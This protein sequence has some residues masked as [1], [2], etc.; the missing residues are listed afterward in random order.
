M[1]QEA[2]TRE[3]AYHQ[4]LKRQMRQQDKRRHLDPDYVPGQDTVY[5]VYGWCPTRTDW[6]LMG[7]VRGKLRVKRLPRVAKKVKARRLGIELLKCVEIETA[8]RYGPPRRQDGL[9]LQVV[10]EL[11]GI[12]IDNAKRKAR[13]ERVRARRAHKRALANA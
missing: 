3:A 4:L 6:L 12:D 2:L 1:E 10:R 11:R 5:V 8:A 9:A 13:R 7:F